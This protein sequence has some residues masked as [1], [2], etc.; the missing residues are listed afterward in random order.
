MNV[1]GYSNPQADELIEKIEST[2]ITY[3]R[4]AYIE[5]VWRIVLDD[6]AYIPLHHQQIVWAMRDNLELP[7]FPFNRPLFRE[8]RLTASGVN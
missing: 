5:E 8:A 1:S 3:A 7:V 4:D 2:M 6:I